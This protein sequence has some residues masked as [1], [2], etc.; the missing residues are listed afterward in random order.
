MI[1]IQPKATLTKV[2]LSKIIIRNNDNY[3]FFDTQ[4]NENPGNIDSRIMRV[5]AQNG[6]NNKYYIQVAPLAN[7]KSN[8]GKNK[9]GVLIFRP[10][11]VVDGI[12]QPDLVKDIVD[13]TALEPEIDVVGENDLDFFGFK[14]EIG[15][16]I[17]VAI[18]FDSP[19]EMKV[20]PKTPL[21]SKFPQSLLTESLTMDTS[22]QNS[23]IF[24]GTAPRIIAAYYAI[25]A[26][27]KL[28]AVALFNQNI[29]V[30]DPNK[31]LAGNKYLLANVVFDGVYVIMADKE[32]VLLIDSILKTVPALQPEID[33]GKIFGTYDESNNF[34]RIVVNNPYQSI[35]NIIIGFEPGIIAN[36]KVIQEQRPK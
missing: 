32:E 15:E 25:R 30:I 36:G 9:N 24:K 35:L 5:L 13:A 33:A 20:T 7:N 6:V 16:V 1:N 22:D 11:L 29:T 17:K 19:T 12:S 27:I 2:T 26:I 8:T 18:M 28:E 10:G 23:L 21:Q 31:V 14:P 4:Y 34:A 3:F